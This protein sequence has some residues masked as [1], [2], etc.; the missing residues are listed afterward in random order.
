MKTKDS[1]TKQSIDPKS[2]DPNTHRRLLRFINRARTPEDLAFAPL[3]EQKVDPQE[4]LKRP[5][6]DEPMQPRLRKQLLKLE[7]AR[8]VIADRDRLSPVHGY[9]HID[10]LVERLRPDWLSKYLKDLMHHLS[11]ASFGEWIDGTVIQTPDTHQDIQVVHAAMLRT[12]WVM[13][14]EAAC[15]IPVSRTPI[16]NPATG[17]IRMPTPPTDNLY[18]CGHSFLSDGKLLAVGGGGENGQSPNPNFG[19][20]FDPTNGPAGTWEPTRDS[21]S[22][23]TYMSHGRW[24]PTL[25]TLGYEPGRVLIASGHPSQMEI[26]DETSGTFSLVTTPA[27]R[28]FS[29]LYPGL[30]MLPGGE[31]FHAPVGFRSGGSAPG[32]DPSNDAS[33]YFDFTAPLAGSWTD[34]GPCDRTKGMSA[35]LLSPTF[36]FAQV[37]VVGG[38]NLARSSTWQMIN[39]STLSPSWGPEQ[40]LP[41]AAG[42]TAPTSRVNVNVV[43]LPDGTVFVSGGASAGEPTWIYDP[44]TNAWSEMAEAPRERKYHSHAVLLPTGEVMSCGWTSNSI[45]IFRPPYLATG[46]TRPVIDSIP[47]LV[48]HGHELVIQTSQASSIQKVV[49]VRP[50]APTH[51]TDSEQRVI[52]L[53]FYASGP[54]TLTATAP[55]GWHPHA[56]AP[57]GYYMLFIIDSNGVPSEAKFIQLH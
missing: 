26:Y 31:I 3:N 38:G 17:E 39:L 27:D 54:D 45:D 25:V 18:C 42:Q 52:R 23:R 51:N 8:E 1:S 50:M 11:I 22:A 37:M 14:V 57:R 28:N 5:D 32:D 2:I 6:V 34:L 56:I 13:F 48:H 40:N 55:N 47:P 43:L 12:G 49:L 16:W 53:Q 35:L 7:D 44:T 29:P 24:Y 21:S 41:M 30:H 9:S 10:Q 15:N 19:W 33:A 4:T 36:P 20:K 46:G